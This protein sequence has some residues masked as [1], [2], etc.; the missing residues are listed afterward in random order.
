MQL[1]RLS[2]IQGF[3]SIY[4]SCVLRSGWRDY[5]QGSPTTLG[6]HAFWNATSVCI[7][8]TLGITALLFSLEVPAPLPR[9][10]G[11]HYGICQYRAPEAERS[12]HFG[13]SMQTQREFLPS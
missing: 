6:W 1:K 2:N 7:P 5:L 3:I 4:L 9:R 10:G 13:V 8:K 12:P 11:V